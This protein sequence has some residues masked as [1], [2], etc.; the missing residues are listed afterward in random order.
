M[1]EKTRVRISIFGKVQGVNFRNGILK[2]A[3]ENN[4][5]G[6]VA[7]MMDGSVLVV[8][9]GERDDVKVLVMY[10]KE[11]P[12][13]AHIDRSEAYYQ[14]YKDEFRKFEIK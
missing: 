10:C 6:Y 2:T 13:S 4:I 11:G 8:A 1:S 7:N 12:K 3:E 14:R 9:E 5:T